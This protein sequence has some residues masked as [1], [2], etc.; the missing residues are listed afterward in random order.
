MYRLREK[1]VKFP[2]ISAK[3]QDILMGGTSYDHE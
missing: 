3:K 2:R 1:I